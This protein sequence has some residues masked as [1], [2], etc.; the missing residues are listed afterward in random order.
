MSNT[1]LVAD[2]RSGI[3]VS[4]LALPLSLGIA[5]ASG[6]PAVAGILT[7]IAA[8]LIASWFKG[9]PLTIKGPAA[10]LI[11]IIL[12]MRQMLLR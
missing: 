12:D 5:L 6:F 7:A 3:M 1:D 2:I 11:A 8:G 4:L 10:G 9:A